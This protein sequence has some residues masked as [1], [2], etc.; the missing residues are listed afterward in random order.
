MHGVIFVTSF[1]NS[2]DSKE[3]HIRKFK[4]NFCASLT[5]RPPAWWNLSWQSHELPSNCNVIEMCAPSMRGE[6]G[7]RRLLS[8][9]WTEDSF[10]LYKK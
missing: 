3:S 9:V 2:L 5:G 4:Y 6:Y 10:G 1:Q 8:S 7:Q